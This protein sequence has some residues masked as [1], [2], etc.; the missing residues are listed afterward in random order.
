MLGQTALGLYGNAWGWVLAYPLVVF[1]LYRKT[2]QTI[3]A[4]GKD[5]FRAPRPA[6]SGTI[7][8]IPTVEWMK[9]RFV[10]G[11]PP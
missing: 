8:M 1:P 5:Y 2:F 4:S 6:L 11:Q 10:P 9:L 3:G 7:A